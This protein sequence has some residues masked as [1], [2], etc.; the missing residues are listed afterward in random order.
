METF[1]FD[2]LSYAL[3]FCKVIIPVVGL[4]VLVIEH[5]GGQREI[6]T[7]ATLQFYSSPLQF[8]YV[9]LLCKQ[10]EMSSATFNK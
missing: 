7:F 2:I 4:H 3:E 8:R 10:T 1:Y 5:V 9:I 6:M